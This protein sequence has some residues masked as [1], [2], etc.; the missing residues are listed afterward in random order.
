MEQHLPGQRVERRNAALGDVEDVKK[1]YRGEIAVCTV[2]L[3][4][5]GRY[6]SCGTEMNNGHSDE[7]DVDVSSA[8]LEVTRLSPAAARRKLGADLRALREQARLT[9]GD[10]AEEIQRSPATMSR[11]ERGTSVPRLVD[12]RALLE[13]YEGRVPD[14]VTDDTRTS[15]LELVRL[16]R[17]DEWFNEYRDVLGSSLSSAELQRFVELETDARQF[18][19]FEPDLVPGLLQTS[20]YATAVAQLYLPDK[21]DHERRRFVEFRRERQRVLDHLQLNVVISEVA[22]AR[23]LGS[24]EVMG[25]QLGTLLEELHNGR[26]NVTIQFA[27]VGLVVPAATRGPFV[28]M[29]FDG[30]DTDVVYLER[31]VGATYLRSPSDVE[32]YASEFDELAAQALDREGSIVLLEEAITKLR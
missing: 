2:D 16:S 4:R 12:V 30:S 27:P 25:E 22:L 21:T 13:V 15:M 20:A 5:A 7:R 29:R 8:R 24:A 26:K 28:V 14:L 1:D 19:S 23:Q 11:L 31:G 17:R 32:Q 9:L 3:A 6:H 10:A 18:L